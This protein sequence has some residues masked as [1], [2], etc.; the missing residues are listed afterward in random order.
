MRASSLTNR[1]RNLPPV[2][3]F[4]KQHK[5][6]RISGNSG[7]GRDPRPCTH[8]FLDGPLAALASASIPN[9]RLNDFY[10]QYAADVEAG[11]ALFIS[12]EAAGEPYKAVLD[13]DFYF[14]E[15]DYK[16]QSLEPTAF[17]HT[18]QDAIGTQFCTSTPNRLVVAAAP[19]GSVFRNGGRLVK[20]GLHLCWPNLSLSHAN[21][22]M[23]RRFLVTLCQEHY[24]SS[25]PINDRF[26]A[27]LAS[28][29]RDI[30]DLNVVKH[31]RCRMIGSSKI[32][33]CEC[34]NGQSAKAY[35]RYARHCMRQQSKENADPNIDE[36]LKRLTCQHFATK[37]LLDYGRV[38]TVHS[39]WRD[40]RRDNFI[41]SYYELLLTLSLRNAPPVVEVDLPSDYLSQE[42]QDENG[43]KAAGD[44]G[45]GGAGGRGKVKFVPVPVATERV[46][47]EHF[48]MYFAELA[49][50]ITNIQFQTKP[51]PVIIVSL[52]QRYCLNKGGEHNSLTTYC[53]IRPYMMTHHCRCN[54]T[55]VRMLCS[56]SNF[57]MRYPISAVL[58]KRL[59]QIER[60]KRPR[61][62]PTDARQ[63]V[64]DATL[65]TANQIQDGE[66]LRKINVYDNCIQQRVDEMTCFDT[67][68]SASQ[69][70]SRSDKRADNN[71]DDVG[72]DVAPS[73][74]KRR[75]NKK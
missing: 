25:F 28:T 27:E 55:P 5:F 20:L 64:R 58:T 52:S 68:L 40:T 3:T 49:P 14:K 10:K 60:V 22:M 45:G 69:K 67:S 63:T 65:P 38:Y 74:K 4:V 47:R 70:E 6:N 57:V 2:Y 30:I 61:T 35:E 34:N 16:Q 44:L 62:A 73:G 51:T 54:C 17:I 9:D 15:F 19:F 24:T 18:L 66:L 48:E 33:K 11:H 39:I 13:F 31:P 37:C 42:F 75:R 26:N 72:D 46:V 32:Q 43:G 59:F 50:A 53:M 12:E 41:P 8:T 36:S 1:S 23:L 7:K 21:L 29:W 56:C 71:S